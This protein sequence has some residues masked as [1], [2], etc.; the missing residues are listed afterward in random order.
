MNGRRAIKLPITN[1]IRITIALRPCLIAS[2]KSIPGSSGSSMVLETLIV[3]EEYAILLLRLLIWPSSISISVLILFNSC[4]I[5]NISD[6]L[7]ALS[8]IWMKRRALR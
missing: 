8:S 2:K 3:R 7:T 6:I 1:W 4:S 5:C